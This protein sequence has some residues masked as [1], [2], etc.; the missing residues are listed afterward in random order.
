MNEWTNKHD[1][2]NSNRQT[3]QTIE[4]ESDG[5]RHVDVLK[6]L[7]CLKMV[8]L[9]HWTLSQWHQQAHPSF[10]HAWYVTTGLLAQLLAGLSTTHTH[11]H[12][13]RPISV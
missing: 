7:Q 4:C 8:E 3:Q 11:I 6:V 13:K 2:G 5:G 9:D 10:H 1:V 12:V